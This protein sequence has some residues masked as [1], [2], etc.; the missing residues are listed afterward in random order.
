MKPIPILGILHYNRPDLLARCIASI[1]NTVATL[2]IIQNGPDSEG[3]ELKWGGIYG[4][5]PTYKI[6]PGSGAQPLLKLLGYYSAA[7]IQKIIIVK[8]PAA[9]VAGGWNEIIKLFPAEWWLIVS[10]DIQ[11]APGDLAKVRETLT[12]E[13]QRNGEARH[14][15]L[16]LACGNHGYAWFA[17]TYHG[18]QAVGLFDENIYPAY[19]ED[20]DWSYRATL[21]GARVETIAG[22]KSVH[23]SLPDG[24]TGS[25]T[26]HSDPVLLQRNA[27]THAGNF[28]YYRAKWG[29][30]NGQEVYKTPF[31]W[32]GV[33]VSYWS[34]DPERRARQRWER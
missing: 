23:G 27:E 34:F 22:V 20:C 7:L 15:P 17:I 9:G 13:A 29:G 10:N 19:L 12:T 16:A 14:R 33:P 8:L 21:A 1:D 32:P 3:V 11:F 30:I 24:Q 18:V 25:C 31:D 6:A 28:E 4:Q 26:I 5:D 2:V